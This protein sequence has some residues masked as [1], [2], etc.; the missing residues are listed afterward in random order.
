MKDCMSEVV[1]IYVKCVKLYWL[2]LKSGS[3][4]AVMGIMY[5][6]GLYRANLISLCIRSCCFTGSGANARE[7][8]C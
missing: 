7:S 3:L 4:K 5:L 8:S 1:K 6:I 2:D